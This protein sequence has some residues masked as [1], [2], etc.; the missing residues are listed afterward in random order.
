MVRATSPT[1][2][3]LA[4]VLGVTVR[5]RHMVC[6]GSLYA[7]RMAGRMHIPT[8]QLEGQTLVLNIGRVNPAIAG[9]DAVSVQRWITTA[10]PDLEDMAPFDWLKAERD[11][12]A[13]PKVAPER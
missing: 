4:E 12:D 9:L 7:I 3:A 6:D 10:D 13:V 5:V 8:F 11:V 2:A 1:P